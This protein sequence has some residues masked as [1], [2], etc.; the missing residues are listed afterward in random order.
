MNINNTCI[1]YNFIMSKYKY[2]IFTIIT[3]IFSIKNSI[4]SKNN[5]FTK[6]N[7]KYFALF[8]V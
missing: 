4:D 6:L 3:P 2:L 5:N 7:Y 1:E 8:F